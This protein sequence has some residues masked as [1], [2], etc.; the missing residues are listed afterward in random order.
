MNLIDNAIKYAEKGLSVVPLQPNSKRP[1]IKFKN[2]LPL[3][4]D[5]IKELWTA[6]P[7]YGIAIQTTL[8]IIIDIDSEDHGNGDGFASFRELPKE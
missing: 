8:L 7:D 2:R 6:H 5:E 1:A 3:T 4:V